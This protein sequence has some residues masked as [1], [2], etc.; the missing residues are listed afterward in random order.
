[1]TK[2]TLRCIIIDPV[3]EHLVNGLEDYGIALDYEP[4]ISKYD[5]TK[6]IDQYDIL[7][8]RN[9]MDLDK[10]LIRKGRK[11][12]IVVR[13]GTGIENIDSEELKR[14]SIT[15][16]NAPGSAVESVA[17]LAVCMM[18][19]AA[20]DVFNDVQ[21]LKNGTFRKETGS[22]LEGKTLGILG[23]GA[24]GGRIA[25]LSKAFKMHTI[26]YDIRDLRQKAAQMGLEFV[27]MKE[28]LSRSDIISVNMSMED[29]TKPV[30]DKSAFK[31]MKNG[32]VIINTA[33]AAAVD[34]G[35]LNKALKDAHIAFYATDVLWSEPPKLKEELE[36][37]ANKRVI[38]TSHI[39]AQTNEAQRRVAE[40]ILHNIK[41][42]LDKTDGSNNK[43][44]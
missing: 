42:A 28:L 25:E 11:L 7:I 14:R 17:E 40:N 21:A 10:T 38:A 29:N 43:L 39:G 6:I 22:E 44:N 35:E 19:M 41:E 33:R 5:L 13:A 36:L 26:V 32:V 23:F 37:I 27:E 30:L 12:K 8:G 1:M 2:L 18:I 34:L 20:R 16:I 15:L 4:H 24:I 31:I 9:R 3:D